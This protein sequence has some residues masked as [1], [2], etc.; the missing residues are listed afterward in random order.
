VFARVVGMADTLPRDQKLPISGHGGKPEGQF[1][2][3]PS[4]EDD[5]AHSGLKA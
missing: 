1:K 5:T 2:T 3:H 4:A